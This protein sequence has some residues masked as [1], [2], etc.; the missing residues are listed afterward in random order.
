MS[1]GSKRFEGKALLYVKKG[2][3]RPAQCRERLHNE[4]QR[5]NFRLLLKRT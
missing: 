5:V 2:T 3:R 1:P 4:K